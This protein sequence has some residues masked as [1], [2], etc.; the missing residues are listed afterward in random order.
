MWK[1]SESTNEEQ[2]FIAKE[3]IINDVETVVKRGHYTLEEIV[4][5]IQDRLV[6]LEPPYTFESGADDA[7][8]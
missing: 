7:N 8:N 6:H 2:A 5:E 4:T 1:M 3:A